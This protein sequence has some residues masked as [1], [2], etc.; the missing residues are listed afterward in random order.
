MV[1]AASLVDMLKT[2]KT[3]NSVLHKRYLNWVKDRVKAYPSTQKHESIQHF[4]EHAGLKSE[5]DDVVIREID[6][7]INH[8]TCIDDMELTES[9]GESD[10]IE[11]ILFNEQIMAMDFT[12]AWNQLPLP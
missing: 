5:A 11:E 8:V 1:N 3:R 12:D 6:R 7:I 4:L 10:E 9:L 2:L